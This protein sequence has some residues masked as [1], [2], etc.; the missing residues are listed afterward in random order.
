VLDEVHDD[1]VRK[2]AHRL[3]LLGLLDACAAQPWFAPDAT[4]IL[5]GHPLT[6]VLLKSL[7]FD[8]APTACAVTLALVVKLLPMFAVH[9]PDRLKALVP[10]LLRVLAHLVCLPAGSTT[11]PLEDSSKGTS[12]SGS[13]PLMGSP[14]DGLY[15]APSPLPGN[16]EILWRKLDEGHDPSSTAPSPYRLFTFLYYLFPCNVIRFLRSPVDYLD[17]HGMPN[18]RHT[19]WA[20]E[21]DEVQIKSL[22]EVR[23]VCSC[24][25]REG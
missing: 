13:S 2:P 11:D 24:P 4:P 22:C 19:T 3:R 15:A 10:R 25:V 20:D 17:G 5:A 21:L 16:E 1:F 7:Q 9:A 8:K 6:G 23:N 18:P 12:S 14:E